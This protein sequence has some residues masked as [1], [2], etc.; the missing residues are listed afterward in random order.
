[1]CA[2]KTTPDIATA[3]HFSA[4]ENIFGVLAVAKKIARQPDP[5][6]AALAHE[7]RNPLSTINLA[8]EML[9]ATAANEDQKIYLDIIMRG[10][11]RIKDLLADL[12]TSY[13]VKEIQYEQYS[14]QEL[15][16]E[17]LVMTDDLIRLKNILV[18]K[19][20]TDQHCK[21][22]INREQMKI[23][24]TNIIINAIEA[25]PLGK[26]QLK[27]ITKTVNHKNI[28][29]ISDNGTGISKENLK[30]IFKPFVTNKPLGMGLGLSTS[31]AILHSNHAKVNVK[32]EE[33]VG[34]V[35]ILSFNRTISLSKDH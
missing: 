24:L 30:N 9:Q 16:E 23:A 4:S 27:I 35:F 34:T 11:G 20:Y 29:E 14:V 1:M 25:M 5:F 13:E 18:N 8:V 19:E 26:G 15:L 6:A 31:L 7:V 12:L 21:I 3:H 10:S 32:S 33:G 2:Q 17:V 28:V 22:L